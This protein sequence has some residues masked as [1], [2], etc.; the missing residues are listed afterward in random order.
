MP[1]LLIKIRFLHCQ[2]S[3]THMAPST[4]ISSKTSLS[5]QSA[6]RDG[7][8]LTCHQDMWSLGYLA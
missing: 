1:V 5:Q 2:H 8:I 3:M 7:E 4:G 6:E